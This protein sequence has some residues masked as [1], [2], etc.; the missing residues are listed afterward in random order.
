ML[1]LACGA[2]C[3]WGRSSALASPCRPGASRKLSE[4][5]H[6]ARRGLFPRSGAAERA[7]RL[8]LVAPLGELHDLHEEVVGI[9]ESSG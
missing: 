5:L 1:C 3:E 9:E 2:C 8:Q 4:Q 7:T 6:R